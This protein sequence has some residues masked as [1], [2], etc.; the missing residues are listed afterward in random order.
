MRITLLWVVSLAWILAMPAQAAPKGQK[1]FAMDPAKFAALKEAQQ[2]I[3]ARKF[4]QSLL[5]AAIFHETNRVR[6]EQKLPALQPDAALSKAAQRHTDAMA[7]TG[8]LTHDAVGKEK[9]NLPVERLRKVGLD[10]MFAAE[11][12]GFDFVVAYESGRQFYLHETKEG[13]RFSYEANGPMLPNQTYLQ[14]A[15]LIVEKWMKSP[16]H[17]ENILAKPARFLG[18]GAAARPVEGNMDRIYATQEFYAPRENRP[19]E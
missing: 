12:I 11:N 18:V 15:K 9:E 19:W 8:T 1:L 4:N 14:F 16:P 3:N 10:P 2:P 5:A 17:R 13:L 7:E 6:L